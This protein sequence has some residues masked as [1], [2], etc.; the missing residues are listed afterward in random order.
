MSLLSSVRE[1]ADPPAP[2]RTVA[3]VAREISATDKE[4]TEIGLQINEL[5]KKF[6]ADAPLL[7]DGRQAFRMSSARP[8]HPD[9]LALEAQRARLLKRWPRLLDEY[10]TLE[11]K[12]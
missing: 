6:P 12:R 7:I 5:R 8:L 10:A 3:E 11:S 9:I 2:T 1:L 4:L